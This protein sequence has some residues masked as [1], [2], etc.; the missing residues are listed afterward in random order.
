MMSPTN[1]IVVLVLLFEWSLFFPFRK[2]NSHRRFIEIPD[3]IRVFGPYWSVMRV[4][5]NIR[6]ETVLFLF[7]QILHRGILRVRG[8]RV[9]KSRVFSI[10]NIS[11]R[12]FLNLLTSLNIPR[13]FIWIPRL[14]WVLRWLVGVPRRFIG[15][16]RRFV[17]I[18]YVFSY[19]SF[20][21]GYGI[22]FFLFTRILVDF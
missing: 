13:G 1:V 4:L 16:P 19:F 11:L 18:P 8:A 21:L 6:L 22:D 9:L 14:G 15:V 10:T 12:G 2:G 20:F 3:Y 7:L 17:G 5:T